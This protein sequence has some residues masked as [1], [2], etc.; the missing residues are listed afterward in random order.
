MTNSEPARYNIEMTF[1]IIHHP[2]N[3]ESAAQH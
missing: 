3:P 2:V 1:K